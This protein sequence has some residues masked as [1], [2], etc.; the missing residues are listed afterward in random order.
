MP[1]TLPY[2]WQL[3]SASTSDRLSSSQS[4]VDTLVVQQKAA[5]VGQV[6]ITRSANLFK[7]G[8]QAPALQID[9]KQVEEA[10]KQLEAHN[11]SEVVYALRRLMK[12]LASHRES[13]RLGFS[14]ALC[15]LISQLKSISAHHLIVLILSYS[16]P[17][18]KVKGQE[19]RDLLFARLFGLYALIRSGVLI[20]A[21]LSEEEDFM[22]VIEIIWLSGRSKTWLR[23]SAGWIIV[24]AVEAMAASKVAWKEDSFL[25]LANKI[26]DAKEVG[27]ESIAIFV[28]LR[29]VS[30]ALSSSS[31]LLPHLSTPD[32][33]AS[34]NLPSLAKILKDG[35]GEDENAQ[36]ISS[37]AGRMQAHFAWDLLLQEYVGGDVKRSEKRAPFPEMFKVLVDEA[38]FSNSASD[39]KKSW[40]FQIFEKAIRTVDINDLPHLF[41]A[42]L[43]RTW[44]NQLA[45]RNRMLY[46]AAQRCVTT[47][48][49]VVKEKPQMGYTI[50]AQLFG[51]NGNARFDATTSTKTVE[52]ILACM[53][54][55]G[56]KQYVDHLIT[57]ICTNT[58]EEVDS[59]RKWPLDQLLV[60]IRNASIPTDDECI[61]N[62]LAFL[63][64]HGFF[65]MKSAKKPSLP[66]MTSLSLLP[67]PPLSTNLVNTCRARFYSCLGEV[68]DQSATHSNPSGK[69][70]RVQGRMASGQSWISKAFD[71]LEEL[72]KDESHFT[73]LYL[74]SSDD[75]FSKGKVFSK[76]LTNASKKAES[77]ERKSKI[78]DLQSL[79]LAGLLYSRKDI[80]SKEVLEDTAIQSLMECADRLVLGKKGEEGE[81]S[82]MELF[83]HCL[84]PFL[85][86]SSAFLRSVATQ[87]FASFSD[88]MNH[89]ALEQLLDQLG[90]NVKEEAEE[91]ADEEADE[92]L[93]VNGDDEEGD[94]DESDE[95][96][97]DSISET[98][99]TSASSSQ[100]G[101]PDPVL[102]AKLQEVLKA[103]GAADSDAG[104]SKDEDDDDEDNDSQAESTASDFNDDQMLLI[105]DKLADIFRMRLGSRKEEEE[106]K[107]ETIA[108]HIKILDLLDVFARKQSSSPLCIDMVLPLFTIAL[109]KDVALGQLRQRASTIL[110]KTLC[111]SKDGINATLPAE[112]V[113]GPMEA[114]HKMATTKLPAP[115]LNLCSTV[116]IYLTKACREDVLV[117]NEIRGLYSS[118]LEDFVQRKS[119]NLKPQFFTDIFQRLP[120]LGFS[121][122]KELLAAASGSQESSKQSY[123][124][125]QALEMIRATLLQLSNTEKKQASDVRSFL[126]EVATVILD[127]VKTEKLRLKEIVKIALD[128]ARLSK[129]MCTT[130]A[131]LQAI[132]SVSKINEAIEA[133]DGTNKLPNSVSLQNV[134]RQ[135]LAITSTSGEA[136]GKSNGK[137]KSGGDE[138]NHGNQV[139]A[140]KKKTTKDKSNAN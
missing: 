28:S 100:E 121:L 65:T 17:S 86:Q 56:V 25:W 35:V 37:G 128:L 138:D 97:S 67:Q 103:A 13:S 132:W 107:K 30:P 75:I 127:T 126:A 46:K 16:S 64:A 53:N 99:A 70:K 112:A 105:D 124:Q 71:I 60:V 80:N 43:M 32:I 123:R 115:S 18:G 47:I 74:R 33:L 122:R 38:L 21:D 110:T 58:A 48:Q 3:A 137:R 98:S 93:G 76:K 73:T 10:E 114:V 20:D 89:N 82:A 4:L 24:Q 102:V 88:E 106:Q 129:K 44:M 101:A 119:S 51:K 63:A 109:E 84:I 117:G 133:L 42:N 94:G 34:A 55:K 52:S 61:C 139:D 140:K 29:K 50:I 1:S 90:F 69:I 45:D 111:K 23:E 68:V 125:L 27:P 14:V 9:G 118:T 49:E 108:L 116:N 91:E 81:P 59:A 5:N 11:C 95:V 31:L 134:L 12:G 72:E 8:L 66:A 96:M 78:D 92:G 79:L 85:E 40:G 39:Q 19:E 77:E 104:S 54:A 130:E 26:C 131:D 6:S 2:Y 120:V 15:E 113:L 136:K 36:N 7:D 87:A 41:T 22:R 57:A 135:L 62:I 83:V